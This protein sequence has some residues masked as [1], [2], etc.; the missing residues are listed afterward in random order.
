MNHI[1]NL[2]NIIAIIVVDRMNWEYIKE[3]VADMFGVGMACFMIWHLWM[4]ATH[5]SFTVVEPNPLI[6]WGEIICTGGFLILTFER[7]LLDT[8][9][10]TARRIISLVK[11]K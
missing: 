2:E 8:V 3:I 1:K 11:R 6:L 7:F 10:S 9:K 4:I 5:G